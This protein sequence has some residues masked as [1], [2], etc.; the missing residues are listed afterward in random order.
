MIE[1]FV[2]KKK[3]LKKEQVLISIFLIAIL[4]LSSGSMVAFAKSNTH[5]VKPDGV[6]DTSDIQNALNLCVGVGPH[7]TVQL[8]AGTYYITSQITVYGFQGNFVGAGQ[9]LTTISVPSGTSLP[10]P[11]VNSAAAPYWTVNPGASN[12]WPSLFTFVGGTFSISGMTITDPNYDAVGSPSTP[13]SPRWY[14][15]CGMTCTGSF[16]NSLFAAI[17]ITGGIPQQPRASAI[18]DHVSVVGAP[19]DAEGP[20]TANMWNGILYGGAFVQPAQNVPGGNFADLILLPGTL[21]VTN[22]VFEGLES[23]P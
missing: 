21:S 2:G 6:N 10:S 4:V 11:T 14:N 8:I 17:Y 16:Y 15:W 7:C 22:G 9:G 18:V 3:I 19:G 20:N 23:G 1:H 13:S 12:P 5:V